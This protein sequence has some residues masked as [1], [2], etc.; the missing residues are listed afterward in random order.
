MTGVLLD[1]NVVSELMR[2]APDAHVE[3]YL[4]TQM[5]SWLSVLTVH[6]MRFGVQTLPQGRRRSS[7]DAALNAIVARWQDSI[8]PVDGPVAETAAHFRAARQAMGRPLHLADAL[9]A[10][11]AAVRGM[12]LATRNT[13]DFDALGIALVNPWEPR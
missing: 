10:G 9:I 1:T 11:T 13:A 8:A 6:E 5:D 12:V 3:A 7:F 2:T 4:S